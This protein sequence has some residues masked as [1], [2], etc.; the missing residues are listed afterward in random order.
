MSGAVTGA[1]TRRRLLAGGATAGAAAAL[2]GLRP[3]PAGAASPGG[4]RR[5]DVAVVGAGLAGLTAARRLHQAG[6]SVAV[7]EA[8]ERVGGRIW[9]HQLGHGRVS[10]RGGTFVGPTQNHVLALAREL[11]VA[12]FGL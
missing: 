3:D 11:R 2:G 5:V 8:R 7:I 4:A 12:T 1:L 6:H 9:N 10:E